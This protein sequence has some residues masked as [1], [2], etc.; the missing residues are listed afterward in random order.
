MMIAGAAWG[1]SASAAFSERTFC[2]T[3]T[4]AGAAP[5]KI[6]VSDD[7]SHPARPG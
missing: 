4:G 5:D 7:R 1:Q 2:Q 6:A 3:H